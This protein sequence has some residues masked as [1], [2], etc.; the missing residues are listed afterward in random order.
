MRDVEVYTQCVEFCSLAAQYERLFSSLSPLPSPLSPLPSPLS[1][2]SHLTH[3]NNLVCLG[4][5]RVQDS[6]TVKGSRSP[7][8]NILPPSRQL[9][10]PSLLSLIC[11]LL[12]P[13]CCQQFDFQPASYISLTITVCSLHMVDLHPDSLA[14]NH[15]AIFLHVVVCSLHTDVCSL[16]YS[17]TA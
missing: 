13:H 7:A 4:R 3:S 16:T 17:Q 1:R 2:S 10:F 8:Q 6:Q 12:S 14:Y 15:T 11:T 9:F 5:F